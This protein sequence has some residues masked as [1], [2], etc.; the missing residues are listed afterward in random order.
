LGLFAEATP[1]PTA[2]AAAS[3]RT[4]QQQNK[5]ARI[6]QRAGAAASS[7]PPETIGGATVSEVGD[8]VRVVF[9]CMPA[10][11]LQKAL[12]AVGFQW[13]PTDGAWQRMASGAAWF[14][15]K[16]LLTAHVPS[17]VAPSPAAPSPSPDA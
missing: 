10:Q 6:E 9:S 5:P 8:R 4:P 17:L 2:A 3:A 1:P 7:R 11:R 12:K 14:E 13:S 15:A 16:R